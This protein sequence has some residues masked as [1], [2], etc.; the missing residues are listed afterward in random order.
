MAKTKP[1]DLSAAIDFLRADLDWS[2][3]F[4]SVRDS[5]AELLE[6]VGQNLTANQV[7]KL[8]PALAVFIGD[9]L[10]DGQSLIISN[11]LG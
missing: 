5:L 6:A 9:L 3:D 2:D 1:Y 7:S 8:D 4:D 11:P 10:D